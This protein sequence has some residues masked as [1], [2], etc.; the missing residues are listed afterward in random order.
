MSYETVY[1]KS[2]NFIWFLLENKFNEKKEINCNKAISSNMDPILLIDNE[3]K[4]D[5]IEDETFKDLFSILNSESTIQGIHSDILNHKSMYNSNKITNE[6]IDNLCKNMK[7]AFFYEHFFL[8]FEDYFDLY[9]NT[10]NNL[11]FKD[12]FLKKPWRFYIALMGV[13]TMKCDYLYRV[14]EELFLETGGDEAWLIYGLDV[15]PEKIKKLAKFNNMLA[16]QPWKIIPDD[17]KEICTK[18]DQN[19]S[20]AWNLSEFIQ[21]A[22]ILTHFQRLANI[23]NSLSIK[24][25]KCAD[26]NSHEENTEISNDNYIKQELLKTLENINNTSGSTKQKTDS[27]LSSASEEP[28]LITEQDFNPNI[29]DENDK[30]RYFSRH[31]HKYCN[32]YL[33]FD[34]H[35]EE[36][37]S[38]L[39]F[40]W[41]DHA[42]YILRNTYPTGIDS[43]NQEIEYLTTLTTNSLGDEQD[44]K[45]NTFPIRYSI[46]C[47]IEKIFGYYHEDYDYSNVNRLLVVE[48][49]KFIKNVA[50]HPKK[51]KPDCFKRMNLAFNNE[52]ILHIIL[53]VTIIK[54]RT[55]LTY[56]ANCVY[57]IIKTIE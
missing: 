36:Y 28:E 3:S 26:S 48:Y 35:S 21:A 14:L 12:G 4:Q 25:R 52:E 13:S 15:V 50:C 41:L 53:L 46:S 34:P 22:L 7:K 42:Y 33:D 1:S 11:L 47:Y 37:K 20:S 17:I 30:D 32:V 29:S 23:S 49:K 2:K 45:L 5:K 38:Y 57:E 51:L 24:L 39:E 10:T 54:E 19:D 8:W 6:Y 56:L 40:N 16:H 31:I 55:Q 9:L 27:L 44:S 43:I 18:N